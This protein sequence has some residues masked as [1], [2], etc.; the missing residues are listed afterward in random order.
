M[1]KI[2]EWQI[3][4]PIRG[5]QQGTLLINRL[6]HQLFRKDTVD[7]TKWLKSEYRAPKLPKPLGTEEITYG[8]KVINTMNHSVYSNRVYPEG[9]QN[10]IANGEI[11][12]VVGQFKNKFHKFKGQPKNTEVEFASQKG[13]KYTFYQS[14]FKEERE[15][16]LE[17]AYAITIHKSQGSEFDTTFVVLPKNSFNLSRELIYTALTRQKGKSDYFIPRG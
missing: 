4:S 15:S 7:Y 8:D 10:Y 17:L 12:I 11:G 9:G 14:D 13:Y 2:E 1:D 5:T 16:T 6:I 3:L